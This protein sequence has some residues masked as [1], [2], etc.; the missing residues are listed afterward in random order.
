MT[1]PQDPVPAVAGG[2]GALHAEPL[3][4]DRAEFARFLRGAQL[5]EPWMPVGRITFGPA[6]DAAGRALTLPPGPVAA[7]VCRARDLPIDVAVPDDPAALGDTVPA[8]MLQPCFWPDPIGPVLRRDRV[9]PLRPAAAAAA[10]ARATPEAEPP[11]WSWSLTFVLVAVLS[12]LA[13]LLAAWFAHRF[14]LPPA[15]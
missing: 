13:L 2:D 6:V 4:F 5:G 8:H 9:R 14:P 15:L 11:G 12:G 7:R 10:R 3:D 1:D